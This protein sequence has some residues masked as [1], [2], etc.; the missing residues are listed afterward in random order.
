MNYLVTYRPLVKNSRGK[1]AIARYGLSPYVDDSCRREPD[2]EAELPSITGLC[3]GAR[4]AP[5][6]SVSD[7]VV[8]LTVKGNYPGYRGDHWRLAAILKVVKRFESHEEAA[9]WYGACELAL[10]R[11]CMVAGNLP[12][13][14]DQTANPHNYPDVR[15][16]DSR[17]RKRV[18]DNGVFLA[19]QPLFLELHKPPVVTRETLIEVFG[20]IPGTQTPPRI[21]DGEYGDLIVLAEIEG[22]VSSNRSCVPL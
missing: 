19:C 12:L 11:N 8:Y 15:F 20:R 18:R 3:R 13:P 4:F 22:Q 2:F 9:A 1:A 7:V 16:W 17:Y 21:S 14:M 5:R 10:P 6:L